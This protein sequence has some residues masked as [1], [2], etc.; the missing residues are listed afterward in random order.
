[1]SF[2]I[3][4][5]LPVIFAVSA[6]LLYSQ[7]PE[8]FVAEIQLPATSVKNQYQS[9]TCWDFATISFIESEL[10]R[11]GCG[12]YDL[13]EMFVIRETYIR[14]AEKYVR[15]HGTISFSGGGEANDVTETINTAGIMPEAVYPGNGFEIKNFSFRKLDSTLLGFVES[16]A[17]DAESVKPD[18]KDSLERILDDFIGPVPETFMWQ[19]R[20]YTPVTFA[21]GLGLH[22]DDYILVGSYTHH[23]YYGKFILEVP[24]NWS[25]GYVYNIPPDEMIQVID[26]SLSRGYSVVWAADNSEDGFSFRNGTAVT[27]ET[28]DSM[29]NLTVLRQQM[30]D[31]FQT[32]DDHGMHITGIAERNG[33]KY[34]IVKNSWGT[35]NM[36]DGYLYASE[37]YVRLKTISVMVHRA[38][39]SEDLKHLINID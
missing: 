28:K 34:Y 26:N 17:K 36:Y 14:K 4:L 24:D 5:L 23:P 29:R 22:M 7:N 33:E 13:S 27:D 6:N 39:L 3:R 31:N 2:K 25:W 1:M 11:I 37:K 9:S 21:E 12:E 38:A 35:G 10:L 32:Q 15:M 8:G 18:W 20:E 30:F 19:G 16:L